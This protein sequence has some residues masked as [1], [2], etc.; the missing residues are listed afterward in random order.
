MQLLPQKEIFPSSVERDFSKLLN[1]SNFGIDCRNNIDN[2]ILEPLQDDLN[3][4]SYIKKLTTIFSDY[5]FR[6]FFSRVYMRDKI[7]Q[8]FQSKT[9][10]LNKEDSSYEAR[11]EYFENKM[12]E[13]P[14][15]VN[16]FA[17]SKNRRKRRFKDLDEKISDCL[18]PT[19][20][21]MVIEFNDRE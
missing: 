8:T 15:A 11:K 16:S 1:N 18:N 2:F 21:K 19:K 20:T 9:F 10:A 14:D 5:T 17:K 13:E 4:I 6:N 12:D 3:E 7:I